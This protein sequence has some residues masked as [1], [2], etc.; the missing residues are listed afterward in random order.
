MSKMTF[1]AR[2]TTVLVQAF[3]RTPVNTPLASGSIRTL[4]V[5]GSDSDDYL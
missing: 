1:L 3:L 2:Q 4:S 5:Q